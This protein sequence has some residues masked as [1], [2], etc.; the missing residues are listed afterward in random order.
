MGSLFI[1]GTPIGNLKDISI[2]A[3]ETLKEVDFILAEDTRVTLKLL[4]KYCIKKHVISYH[5]HNKNSKT[6]NV[7]EKLKKGEKAAIVSDAGMPLICDPG[8]ELVR[9][10][11]E[12]KINVFV[13]PGPCALVS[14]LALS[15][16]ACSR[17]TFYGFLPVNRN[18]KIKTL[19]FLKTLPHIVVLYEAPHK[20]IKTLKDL[21]NYF[22]DRQV[23][24]VKEIT[25]IHE[26]VILNKLSKMVEHFQTKEKPKG[27]FVLIVEG[28]EEN[29]K[30]ETNL[31]DVLNFA[32]SLINGGEKPTTAAKKATENTNFKKNYIY[33]KL[34][35]SL[36]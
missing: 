16:M 21:L 34:V 26:T 35:N 36:K 30:E 7:M 27:E 28:N 17:F 19:N 8:S 18:N 23:V 12:E 14:A 2:R 6:F 22:G 15:G 4:N 13:V 3:I 24:A 31:E 1:V 32:Q 10:C 25:K 33:K 9:R 20:L 29:A 5:E 11:Y